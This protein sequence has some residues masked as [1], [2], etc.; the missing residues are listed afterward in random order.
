MS[1]D[2]AERI[3]FEPAAGGSGGHTYT[4]TDT[5]GSGSWWYFLSDIDTYGVETFHLPDTQTAIYSQT[6]FL[7][8]LVGK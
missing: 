4:F 6:T 8:L 2:E 5:P 1:V 3:H 7:P